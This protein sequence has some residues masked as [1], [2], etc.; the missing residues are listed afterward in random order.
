MTHERRVLLAVFAGGVAGTLA[1]VGLTEA[2]APE[3]GHWPWAT[4]I[5]NVI[6]AAVI[7]WVMGRSPDR[8]PISVYRHPL[9]GTG[10]CGALTTFSTF[11]LEILHMLDAGDA[12]LALG[13]IG[14]SVALGMLA[15]MAT[16]AL[17][18]R[19]HSGA[20]A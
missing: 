8:G 9:L 10:L 1:R 14:A 20:P 19:P 5:V 13:Y 2:W 17:A 6:G 16:T 11:Q 18:R 3:P 7:G 15:V 12:G 4:F